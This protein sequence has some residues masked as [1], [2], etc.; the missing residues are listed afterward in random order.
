VI[1]RLADDLDVADDGVLHLRI[2]FECFDAGQRLD[3]AASAVD[4]FGNVPK[5]IFDALRMPHKSRAFCKTSLRNFGGNALGVRT[6][7]GT[8]SNVSASRLNV[9]SV[10][11]LVFSAGSTSKSRSLCPSSVPV[12]TD[13]KMRG[14]DKP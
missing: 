6:E 11:R 8:P 10:K 5:A 13:P 14:C 1:H 2:F 7:T 3:M 12:R 4:S 9:A